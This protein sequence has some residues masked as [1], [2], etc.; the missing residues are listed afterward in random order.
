MRSISILQ[1]SLKVFNVSA[2]SRNLAVQELTKKFLNSKKIDQ[3]KIP[4]EVNSDLELVFNSEKRSF[5]EIVFTINLARI[6]DLNFKSTKDLYACNPRPVYEQGIKPILDSNGVPCTQSGP[7]NVTKATKAITDQWA[8]MKSPKEVGMATYRLAKYID[9]LDKSGL[10]ILASSMGRLLKKDAI[11]VTSLNIKSD[12]SSDS[13]VLQEISRTLIIEALD[14]GNTAQR[15]IGTLLDLHKEISSSSTI[16]NGT[17]DS[18][19]TT[20]LTSKKVGDLSVYKKTGSVISIYEVTLK[21]F[22]EQR[23][24]ECSQSLIGNLGNEAGSKSEVIVLCR[25]EDMPS[26]AISAAEKGIVLG[27]FTDKFGIRYNFIDLFQWVSIRILELDQEFRA[28]YF[29]RL[30]SYVNRV[31]TPLKVKSKWAEIIGKYSEK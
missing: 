21:E 12:P 11:H 14:G 5:R 25:Q 24:S 7:L 17:E 6:L 4:T 1:S 15:V 26:I 23:I 3:G 8:A 27:I 20:N 10:E 19:S 18:A 29:S 30:E 13:S 16:V 28:E 2:E 9:S 31:K 22:T